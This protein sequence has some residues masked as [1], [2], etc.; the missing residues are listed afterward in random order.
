MDDIVRLN[1]GGCLY[2][3]WRS[4][5]TRYPDSKLAAMFSG[6]PDPSVLR[7]AGGAFFMDR[8]GPIFRHVLGFLHRGRLILPKGFTEWDLLAAEAKYYKIRAL[9]TAIHYETSYED[10]YEFIWLTACANVS[11]SYRGILALYRLEPLHEFFSAYCNQ[12]AGWEIVYEYTL[13]LPPGIETNVHEDFE[14]RKV[15]IFKDI[16]RHGYRLR[17]RSYTLN[18][19]G[20]KEFKWKFAEPISRR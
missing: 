20:V 5:L 11:Y 13:N 2:R 4:T 18:P 8:D 19:A 6:E 15:E 10:E 9:N 7:D 1:V 14:R 3:T 17:E 12:Q 16:L